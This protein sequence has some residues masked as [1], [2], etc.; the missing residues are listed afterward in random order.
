M[1][2]KSCGWSRHPGGANVAF[3]T[4]FGRTRPLAPPISRD[5]SDDTRDWMDDTTRGRVSP[6]V[7]SLSTRVVHPVTRKRHRHIG[8]R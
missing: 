2:R 1:S 6:R 3:A 4:R 5:R 8:S 7:V